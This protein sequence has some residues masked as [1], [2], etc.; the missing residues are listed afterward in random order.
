MAD[1]QFDLPAEPEVTSPDSPE[2]SPPRPVS[3]LTPATFAFLSGG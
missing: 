2:F 1:G 3:P